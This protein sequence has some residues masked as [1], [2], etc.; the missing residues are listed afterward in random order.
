M[1]PTRIGV[2][3]VRLTADRPYDEFTAAFE[4]QVGLCDPS[5]YPG[6]SSLA[7]GRPRFPLPLRRT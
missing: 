3:H 1:S 7:S 4:G 5:V 2:E 6:G